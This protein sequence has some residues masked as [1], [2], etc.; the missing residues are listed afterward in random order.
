MNNFY[1][2]QINQQLPPCSVNNDTE[3]PYTRKRFSAFLY[4]LLFSRES[5]TTSS[6]LETIHVQ[7]R[8]KTFP[9]ARC[10]NHYLLYNMFYLCFC[11]NKKFVINHNCELFTIISDVPAI[12][13]FT[14]QRTI[15]LDLGQKWTSLR[16]SPNFPRK[17]IYLE[18]IINITIHECMLGIHRYTFYSL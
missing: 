14:L 12:I 3:A 8:R 10:L 15:E 2:Q 5:R 11:Y 17:I 1:S 16:R 6:L 13:P 4:C 7:K 18:N 9:C